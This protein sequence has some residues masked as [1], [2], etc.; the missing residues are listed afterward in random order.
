MA[1][2]TDVPTENLHQTLAVLDARTG[3]SWGHSA[4]AKEGTVL[5]PDGTV[6]KATKRQ[7]EAELV[8]RGRVD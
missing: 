7:I 4:G 2:L 1:D 3:G 8:A 6:S 5:H